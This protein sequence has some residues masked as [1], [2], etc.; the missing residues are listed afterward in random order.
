MAADVFTIGYSG[1]SFAEVLGLLRENTITAIADVRS[2]PFSK[3]HVEFNQDALKRELAAA[4]IAYV[5]L[6]VELGART[7]DESCYVEGK[8]QYERLAMT[9]PFRAGL[10]RVE[11]GRATHRIAL[12]CAE[13]DPLM[14]HRSILVSR[15][16]TARGVSVRHILETGLVEEHEATMRRLMQALRIAEIYPSWTEDE[17]IALAYQTRGEQIAYARES[18]DGLQFDLW[19][20][21]SAR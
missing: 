10:E 7:S 20:Q 9:A 15:H 6:G 18:D 8:V 3:F 16:L 14:C 1:R 13:S 12:L 2:Q 4:G 21:A 11:K 17:R 19:G 5:F